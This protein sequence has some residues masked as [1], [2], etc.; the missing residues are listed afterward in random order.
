MSELP[1]GAIGNKD[2]MTEEELAGKHIDGATGLVFETEEDYLAFKHPENV[3]VPGTDTED[4][5]GND[6]AE[7]AA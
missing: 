7:E 3:E 6:E 5:G 4:E 1:Q 2:D